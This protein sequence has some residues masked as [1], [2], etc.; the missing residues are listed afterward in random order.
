MIKSGLKTLSLV[1][2]SL[3]I[4]VSC[5]EQDISRMMVLPPDSAGDTFSSSCSRPRVSGFTLS[6]SCSDSSGNRRNASLSFANC[7][8]NYDGNLSRFDGR[9]DELFTR[10]CYSSG[11]R[12]VC[13]CQQPTGGWRKCSINFDDIFTAINGELRC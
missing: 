4:L 8:K 9:A 11:M 7:L 13:E 6:A 3:S 5:T 12:L 2:M 1:L 10:K